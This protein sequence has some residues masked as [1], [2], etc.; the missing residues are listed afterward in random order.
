MSRMVN[1]LIATGSLKSDAVID[2]FSEIQRIEFVPEDFYNSA[3]ADIPL[4]V[5][6]GEMIAEPQVAAIMMELLDAERGQH[7]FVAGI[8]SGWMVALL[9]YIVGNK[10]HVVSADI[11]QSLLRLGSR[12]IDKYQMIKRGVVEVI[13]SDPLEGCPK[14][15]PFDRILV[16]IPLNEDPSTLK[17]QLKVGGVMVLPMYNEIRMIRRE[18]EGFVRDV[19]PGFS[20]IPLTV[21]G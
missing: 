18:D 8:S 7:V 6:H 11:H 5:G 4:P 21:R 19:Y 2:A 10:G 14:Q 20:Y 13:Q 3:D 1:N 9:G 12:N 16:T 15:A 17:E